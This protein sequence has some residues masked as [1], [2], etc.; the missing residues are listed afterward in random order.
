MNGVR[1]PGRVQVVAPTPAELGERL[2]RRRGGQV[3]QVPGV[4]EVSPP[5]PVNVDVDQ[6][7]PVVEDPQVA[8]QEAMDA[9]RQRV[10]SHQVVP[11]ATSTGAGAAEPSSLEDR[12]D[13]WLKAREHREAEDAA[14]RARE[15]RE[16]AAVGGPCQF[17][18]LV[19]SWERGE[20]GH[21]VGHWYD[22]GRTC[23]WCQ[24]D[25]SDFGVTELEHRA[26]VLRKL[27]PEDVVKFWDDKH[28]LEKCAGFRW[29]RDTPGATT[30]EHVGERF[31]YAD[32]DGLTAALRPAPLQQ[33]TRDPCPRCG[34][35]SRWM[36]TRGY[37]GV[38]YTAVTVETW[39]CDGCRHVADL[40]D[41]M[42]RLSGLGLPAVESLGPAAGVVLGVAWW[43]DAPNGGGVDPPCPS[44][45][46]FGY[47][48][49]G[50][51]CRRALE[52]FPNGRHWRSVSAL[53]RARELAAGL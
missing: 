15:E 41:L 13:A 2:R 21:P 30:G 43:R 5:V 29:W 50:A 53:V 52:L 22:D 25:R 23:T 32:Q 19:R 37:Q 9:L 1:W 42:G 45:E 38:G 48:D 49:R 36:W 34:C 6:A 44:A 35:P 46:P 17:C 7:P 8:R 26:M 20:D 10:K 27:I 18:G 11:V 4:V 31:A 16:R 14:R 3:G 33:V 40:T 12:F 24:G 28:L 47:V 39:Q 51:V